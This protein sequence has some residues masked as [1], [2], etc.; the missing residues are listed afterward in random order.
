[1]FSDY[2]QAE[3]YLGDFFN[4]G[5][6]GNEPTNPGIYRAIRRLIET[7]SNVYGSRLSS[8]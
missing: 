5:Q 7:T 8:H 6:W 2:H 1:M 4:G 3:S